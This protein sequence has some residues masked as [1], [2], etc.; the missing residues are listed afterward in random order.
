MPLVALCLLAVAL[1]VLAEETA[2]QEQGKVAAAKSCQKCGDGYC[3]PSC[4][5]ERTCPAD[6]APQT[7][8]AAPAA[9]R[10]GKCGDGQCVASCG[11]NAQNC[12]QDCGVPSASAT[13]Q[14]DEA[15][16]P[17]AEVKKE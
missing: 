5:N 7:K 15:A 12:P 1:P 14:C 17:K 6:C 13:A 2:T 10:C 3:A 11:E 4:E 8:M 9:A 16:K